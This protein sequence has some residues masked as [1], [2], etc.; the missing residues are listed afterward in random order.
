ML[1]K[2]VLYRFASLTLISI[3]AVLM[4]KAVLLAGPYLSFCW[5]AL[6]GASLL[7]VLCMVIRP[8]MMKKNIRLLCGHVRYS[9]IAVILYGIMQLVTFIVFTKGFVGFS[10][11]LFQLSAVINVF[12]GYFLFKEKGF[13]PR[14]AGSAVMIAGALLIMTA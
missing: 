12:L 8:G 9:A 7:L 14:L 3:E 6:A 4:K 10:L 2:G 13:L 11:A 1:S 5:W